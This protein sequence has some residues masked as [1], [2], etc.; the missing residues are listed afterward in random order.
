MNYILRR[1]GLHAASVKTH[2]VEPFYTYILLQVDRALSLNFTF[3]TENFPHSE[4]L[5]IPEISK[6]AE[7]CIRHI[8]MRDTKNRVLRLNAKIEPRPGLSLKVG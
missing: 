4:S 5:N 2:S 8:E 3:S 6:G 1:L 7:S